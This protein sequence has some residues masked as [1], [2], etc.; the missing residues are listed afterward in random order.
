MKRF[1]LPVVIAVVAFGGFTSCKEGVEASDAR[2]PVLKD[3]LASIFPTWQS[4]QIYKQ[5]DNTIADVVIGDKTFYAAAPEEKAKKAALLGQMIQR[6]Y[7]ADGHFEKGELVVTTDIKNTSQHPA[8]G[9][10][11]PIPF[12]N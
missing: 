12:G 1:V 4:A 10:S 6:I 7:G 3:S 2:W 8:D 11:T 5:Q 9:V